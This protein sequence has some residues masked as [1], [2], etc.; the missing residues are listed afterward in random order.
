[1]V[2]TPRAEAEA[3]GMLKVCAAPDEDILKSVPEV[4]VA[5]V[6]VLPVNPFRLVIPDPATSK[7][8]MGIFLTS[9]LVMVSKLSA[10][11]LVPACTPVRVR[12]L[13]PF[14][15]RAVAGALV[16]TPSLLLV[17]SQKRLALF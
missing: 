11:V 10:V 2:T 12:G 8:D 1:M 9:P 5:K 3:S 7:V 16:P 17:A 13:V 6:C 14:T 4:P 15:C